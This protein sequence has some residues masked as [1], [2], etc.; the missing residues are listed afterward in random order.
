MLSS[1]VHAHTRRRLRRRLRRRVR[2][3]V[4]RRRG[5]LPT[6]RLLELR[7]P[8]ESTHAHERLH[9]LLELLEDVEGVEGA[10]WAWG[11]KGVAWAAAEERW[12]SAASEGAA[13]LVLSA[14]LCS[15]L[16]HDLW[17]TARTMA[18][19]ALE[20]LAPQQPV[21]VGLARTR[22]RGRDVALLAFLHLGAR[23]RA[24]FSR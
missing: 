2:R 1:L 18:I 19:H 6:R 5:Q 3:W 10:K 4:R 22:P 20:R 21:F 7:W 9:P 11:R 14:L 13:I 8:E 24:S 12:R 15:L 17:C 23:R 16:L